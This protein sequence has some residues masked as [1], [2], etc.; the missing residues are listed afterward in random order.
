MV[1]IFDNSKREEIDM[2]RLCSRRN[3]EIVDHFVF[4]MVIHFVLNLVELLLLIF[5]IFMIYLV[6]SMMFG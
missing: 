1:I 4:V 6:L 5:I 2:A 3:A